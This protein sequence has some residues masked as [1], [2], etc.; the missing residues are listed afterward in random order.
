ME[1]GATEINDHKR[2]IETLENKNS[3]CEKEQLKLAL[4]IENLK[5]GKIKNLEDFQKTVSDRLWAI[6]LSLIPIVIGLAVSFFVSLNDRAQN[7]KTTKAISNDA[8]LYCPV[9][10]L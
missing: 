3:H 9:T 4:D 7:S 2:Q 8:A 10:R 5:N 6:Q 1:K